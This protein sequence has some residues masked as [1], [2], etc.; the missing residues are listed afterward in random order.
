MTRVNLPDGKCS[1]DPEKILQAQKDF[2][3]E[4]YMADASVKF[5]LENPTSSMVTIVDKTML[6]Q[7]I[8]SDETARAVKVLKKEKSPGVD[9]LTVEFYH[10]FWHVLSDL[11]VNALNQAIAEGQLHLSA[12]RGIIILIP[13]KDRD[14]LEL[15]NW[16]PL[17]MLTM[18]YKILATVLANR[19]KVVLPYIISEDQT[20][21]MANRQITTTIRR[22]IDVFDLAEKLK[23]PGVPGMC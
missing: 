6:D 19:L 22:T 13:K 10:T 17:T 5:Q 1:S 15:K 9:G 16:R 21:F 8:A 23:I 18:D 3:S 4:L 20:G 12:R 14:V 2:Y 11:Y 7:D